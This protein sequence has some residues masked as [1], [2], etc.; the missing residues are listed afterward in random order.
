MIH[1]IDYKFPKDVLLQEY[2]KLFDSKTEI[3]EP[4]SKRFSGFWLMWNT[5]VTKKI[6]KDF[7]EYYKIPYKYI[8]NFLYVEPNGFLPWHSDQENSMS[9]I[10]CILT[11]DPVAIQF[12]EGQYIYDT[13]LVDVASMHQVQNN[14]TPRILFRITFQENEATFNKIKEIICQKF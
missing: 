14:N 13:A 10:N 12:K 4:D 5:D 3:Q 8:V 9:A 11:P 7:V 6:A 2:K 1:E